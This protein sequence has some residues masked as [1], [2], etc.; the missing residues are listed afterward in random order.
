MT[1]TSLD[2]SRRLKELGCPQTSAGFFHLLNSHKAAIGCEYYRHGRAPN[3]QRIAAYTTDQIL[4]WLPKGVDL[5]KER[6]Y[7][8]DG[9]Y[10]AGL[11]PDGSG[12]RPKVYSK[13][14]YYHASP[15]EA[16]GLLLESL[17]KDGVIDVK[18]LT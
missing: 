1:T 14:W 10:S 18:K 5:H 9:E 6:E 17:I 7:E 2:L 13:D 16:L 8:T 12:T 4:N 15:C 3:D 11:D